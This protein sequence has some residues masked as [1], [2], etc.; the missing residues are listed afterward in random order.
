MSVSDRGGLIAG[1]G[2]SG[3]EKLKNMGSFT[4]CSCN[5]KLNRV[6]SWNSYHS[7]GWWKKKKESGR[8]GSQQLVLRS[9][10]GWGSL[11]HWGGPVVLSDHPEGHGWMLEGLGWS[12]LVTSPAASRVRFGLGV[13]TL[14]GSWS[15]SSLPLM[16]S[17]TQPRSQKKVSPPTCLLLLPCQNTPRNWLVI[18]SGKLSFRS[19][20]S[21]F[22]EKRR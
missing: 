11:D 13:S 8:R 14:V 12:C 15:H 3:A 6:S 17:Q 7:S 1:S 2:Y 19:F 9:L 5:P 18:E 4:M 20:N 16:E 21:S 22:S 10:R